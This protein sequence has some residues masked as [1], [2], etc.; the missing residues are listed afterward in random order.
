MGGPERLS[1]TTSPRARFPCLQRQRGRG[2]HHSLFPLL[3]FFPADP[4]LWLAFSGEKSIFC[5]VCFFVCPTWD[6]RRPAYGPSPKLETPHG[7]ISWESSI[8]HRIGKEKRKRTVV[9][10]S[11]GVRR[12]LFRRLVAR[13]PT[14]VVEVACWLGR[15]STALVVTAAVPWDLVSQG[16][17]A[18]AAGPEWESRVAPLAP[19]LAHKASRL[20]GAEVLSS[21]AIPPSSALEC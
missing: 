13:I 5:F 2:S 6:F 9:R 18:T 11:R 15:H 17:E 14:A 7:G 21:F 1:L 20:P 16:T 3:S 19:L 8:N 10:P 4:S 12:L